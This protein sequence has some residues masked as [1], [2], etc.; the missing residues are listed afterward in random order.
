VSIKLVLLGDIVSQN[1]WECMT[2]RMRINN[3]ED[4]TR[5]NNE[6]KLR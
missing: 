5:V 4:K 2:R 1:G 6:D 3:F